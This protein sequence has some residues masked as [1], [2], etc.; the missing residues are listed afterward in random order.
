MQMH[1]KINRKSAKAHHQV[2]AHQ[3]SVLVDCRAVHLHRLHGLDPIA[4]HLACDLQA[5]NWL[6][7]RPSTGWYTVLSLK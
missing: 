4:L 7:C 5:I 2:P 3:K 6:G 1:N